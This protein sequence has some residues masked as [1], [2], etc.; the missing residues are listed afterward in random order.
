M[1]FNTITNRVTSSAVVPDHS[2]R[3]ENN[4]K[5]ILLATTMLL[6]LLAQT[7]TL[8][9]EESIYDEPQTG[10][11]GTINRS[12][13]NYKDARQQNID[14][15]K[16][17][18]MEVR[19]Q[20][21]DIIA[22]PSRFDENIIPEEVAIKEIPEAVTPII[23]PVQ[24]KEVLITE[25]SKPKLDNIKKKQSPQ[26]LKTVPSLTL[27]PAKKVHT[28]IV[29]NNVAAVTKNKP[30]YNKHG[31][32]G[33]L[34]DQKTERWSCIHD[35]QNGLMW[36]VKSNDDSMRDPNNLYSWFKS[37][38][39][40]ALANGIADGGR[41]QG[42]S[43]CDTSAYVQAMNEQNFCGHN[44]WH[45]PTREQMQTLVYLKN[46]NEPVKINKNYFPETVASWYWT[47]SENNDNDNFAWYVLFRN[48]VALSDLKER[49]K[50]I[51]LVRHTT[52]QVASY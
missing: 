4:I 48:G 49:P 28:D 29:K 24:K 36:E 26:K 14:G 22:N 12:P 5:I 45:L 38:E 43:A 50:H 25:Y 19:D 20:I 39:T 17:E 13:T 18:V 21:N 33:K 15:V 41:C 51:R 7:K 31:N 16:Y 42:D 34:L 35:T 30:V 27:L 10:N 46:D 8:S 6:S 1:I 47:A 40:L 3:V 32:D 11:A 37:D 52:Q 2:C 44:D 9:A 23:P